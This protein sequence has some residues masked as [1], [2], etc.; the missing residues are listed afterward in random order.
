MKHLLCPAFLKFFYAC[1]G[2]R[3]EVSD[4]F[5]TKRTMSFAIFQENVLY[6]FKILQIASQCVICEL[7]IWTL[8][9]YSGMVLMVNCWYYRILFDANGCVSTSQCQLNIMDVFLH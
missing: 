2:E 6:F 1:F 7:L 3:N 5:F 9:M 4:C 8:L